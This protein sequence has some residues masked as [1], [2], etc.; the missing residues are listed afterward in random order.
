M[1]APSGDGS[2]L[3]EQVNNLRQEL[4]WYYR[5]TDLADY[6]PGHAKTSRNAIKAREA[7]LLENLKELSTIDD[8]YALE[9]TNTIPLREIQSRLRPDESILEYFLARG[10]IYAC[11]ITNTGVEFARLAS[12]GRIRE[13]LLMLH[14]QFSM[15]QF[16]KTHRSRSEEP[17]ED[18]TLRRLH[19][20]LIQPVKNQLGRRL[21]LVPAG[22]LH[23]VPFHALFDG[24]NHLYEKYVVSYAG[25]AS[26]YHLGEIRPLL[27]AS[28]DRI[29]LANA[30][31]AGEIAGGL[32]QAQV[33]SNDDILRII[34]NN[35]I[36]RFVHFATH[37]ES[38]QDNTLFSTIAAGAAKLSLLDIF[39][40]RLPCSILSLTG[41]GPGLHTGG[42]GHEISALGRAFEV[43]GARSVLM[44][45]WNTDR[46]AEEAFVAQ[47]YAALSIQSD[48]AVAYQ[49]ALRLTR[50]RFHHPYFW[51][52]F[53]LRGN[54]DRE[55]SAP[56]ASY[57]EI[58]V[59]R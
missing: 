53:V 12:V 54:V 45:V 9:T 6:Q 46:E 49:E 15:L 52:S 19:D 22:L 47:F 29:L 2:A 44:P 41:T 34:K 5:Q 31:S 1:P 32:P 28:V 25:S 4:N 58:E 38:R 3:V 33:V 59:E 10:A 35:E 57:F 39:T 50:T 36:G 11:V 14:S 43:A 21:I 55:S 20:E 13:L 16:K 8:V 17:F 26:T 23:Y 56:N 27:Q 7:L 37:V 30:K 51:A 48:K 24:E 42:D 40:L 18:G